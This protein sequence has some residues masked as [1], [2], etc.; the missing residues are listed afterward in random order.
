MRI[1]SFLLS[2]S[3]VLAAVASSAHQQQQQQHHDH[4]D[5][6]SETQ[7]RPLNI[8]H[9]GYSGIIP[10]HTREAYRAAIDAGAD[11][12]EC[13][14]GMTKDHH[15][16]CLH[17]MWLNHTTDVASHPEFADRVRTYEVDGYGTLTDYF[18]VDFTLEELRTLGKV[19]Q[20][21][22][23]DQSMNGK[24][25]IAT[26]EEYLQIA[27]S[28]NRTVGIYPE[29]KEPAWLN[30]HPVMEGKSYEKLV[31]DTLQ[32]HGYSQ[33]TD[34]AFLQTFDENCLKTLSEL[35]ELK[36]IMLIEFDVP[37][38]KLDE[39]AKIAH[40]VGPWK[41]QIVPT[42]DL[43]GGKTSLLEP[44]DLVKKLH[45]RG[46]KVH[47]Y[48]F[49]NEDRYLAVQFGQDPYAE[50]EYFMK[51]GIDG[52]FTDHTGSLARYFQYTMPDAVPDMTS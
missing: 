34:A 44:T 22:Y 43:P 10:E 14:L 26:F 18:S 23:R 48:T 32:K 11:F 42:K 15:F 47:P 46:L 7:H 37:D 31:V 39:W 45:D 16:V 33:K 5:D 29:L 49:R 17:E 8:A 1:A 4:C 51:M 27:K 19:Q 25:K 38:S 20:H 36:L 3:A 30:K 52:F 41:N 35:T 21:A 24:Y 9:R 28:A 40:G 12:I 2:A 13:D 50:Y 6:G